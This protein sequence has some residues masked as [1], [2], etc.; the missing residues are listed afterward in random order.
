MYPSQEPHL[1]VPKW[2]KVSREKKKQHAAKCFCNF[3]GTFFTV[4][5]SYPPNLPTPWCTQQ[6]QRLSLR[7]SRA[8]HGAKT[9]LAPLRSAGDFPCARPW[10]KEFPCFFL[11]EETSLVCL[12][13]RSTRSISDPLG[14]RLLLCDRDGS[15]VRRTRN[16]GGAGDPSS[17]SVLQC[18]RNLI[19]AGDPRS[20]TEQLLQWLLSLAHL[21]HA[22]RSWYSVVPWASSEK[23]WFFPKPSMILSWLGLLK[24]KNICGFAY[25]VPPCAKFMLQ[26]YYRKKMTYGVYASW[27]ISF[28]VW[29]LYTT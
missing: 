5:I 15:S 27:F 24:Q 22:W 18:W 25:T 11:S 6:H 19:D 14:Q 20:A 13:W 4:N 28:V 16:I 10:A 26:E 8:F 2:E 7:Q 3:G 1:S 23:W 9:F 21:Y 17:A 12:H 29:I